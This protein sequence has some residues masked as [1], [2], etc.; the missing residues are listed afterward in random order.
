MVHQDFNWVFFFL[1]KYH[2]KFD[3]GH[4]SASKLGGQTSDATTT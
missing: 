1:L 2:L 3:E 4:D